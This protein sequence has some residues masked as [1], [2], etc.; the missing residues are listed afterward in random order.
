MVP[1]LDADKFAGHSEPQ[2]DAKFNRECE[3]SRPQ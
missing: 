3:Y 2:S 1:A